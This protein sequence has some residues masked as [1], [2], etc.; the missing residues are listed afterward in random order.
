MRSRLSA[1][2]RRSLEAD[3][4]PLVR[5]SA[6]DFRLPAGRHQCH[7]GSCG[8]LLQTSDCL[9]ADMDVTRGAAIGQ[10]ILYRQAVSISPFRFTAGARVAG[11]ALLAAAAGCRGER[12]AVV[13]L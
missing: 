12:P 8:V 9:L 13:R 4:A 10:S 3:C 6:G 2:L 7:Q 11:C 5:R 1:A